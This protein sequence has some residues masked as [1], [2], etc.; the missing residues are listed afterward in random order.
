[1]LRARFNDARFFWDT[2]QK[3]PLTQRVEMLKAVTFQKDLGSY[4]EKTLRVEALA[5]NLA[6]DLRSQGHSV[7]H[8]PVSAAAHFSKADLTT[9]LVKE[10]TELQGIIGGLY[11]RSQGLHGSEADSEFVRRVADAI[12]DQYKPESTEDSVPRTVDGAILSIA[13]KADTI[14]GMFGLGLTPSGSKDPFALRRQA[15]GI[16]KILAEHKLPIPLN[17]IIGAAA[18]QYHTHAKTDLGRLD[19]YKLRL[20]HVL[21]GMTPADV[22]LSRGDEV[23]AFFVERLQFYLRDVKGIAYDVINATLATGADDVVDAIA[24]AEA[25]KQVRTSEDFAP[26]FIA[27]KRIRNIIKQAREKQ[28]KILEASPLSHETSIESAIWDQIQPIGNEYLQ[29]CGQK[30]YAGALKVLARLRAPVDLYF[31]K[32]MVMVENAE[33]RANRLGVLN[34]LLVTFNKVADLSE[35]VVESK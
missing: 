11:V 3:I 13:D 5:G 10:F 17:V 20:R 12:Y 26:L 1:V 4:Y 30:D 16:I 2:D 7:E 35:L 8:E 23:A 19:D 25:I 22:K 21:S 9:E 28:F 6:G 29:R 32:V 31:D 15:N 27:F 33:V 24:R 18:D 34:Y 14:V